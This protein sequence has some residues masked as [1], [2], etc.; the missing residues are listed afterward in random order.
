[1]PIYA[2]LAHFGFARPAAFQIPKSLRCQRNLNPT[3]TVH[4]LQASHHGQ[5]GQS[6]TTATNMM[7]LSSRIT[8][9]IFQGLNQPKTDYYDDKNKPMA[10]MRSYSAA[11]AS[12]GSIVPPGA[13]CPWNHQDVAHG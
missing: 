12:A 9:L 1:M 4:R 7:R 3:Q 13:S 10:K 8:L 5:R 11:Q 2:H 6:C